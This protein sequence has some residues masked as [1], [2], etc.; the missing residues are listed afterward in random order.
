MIK[1]RID[2]YQHLVGEMWIYTPHVNSNLF[3]YKD[4]TLTWRY[5]MLVKSVFPSAKVVCITTNTI[6]PHT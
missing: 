1:F 6:S 3:N 2:T 4:M 5:L